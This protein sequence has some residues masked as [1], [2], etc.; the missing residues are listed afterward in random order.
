MTLPIETSRGAPFEAPMMGGEGNINLGQIF[1]ALWRRRTVFLSVAFSITVLGFIVLKLLTPLYDST[2]VLVLAAHQDGVVDMQQSYM[3]APPSDPVVRAEVDALKSRT[4]ID[5]VIDRA[6]LMMDPEF[7]QYARPLKP[8]PILCFPARLFPGFLQVKLGCRKPDSSQLAPEQVKYNVASQVLQSFSVTPDPKTYTVK[9]DVSSK[10]TQKAARLANLWADEYMGAQ[11][12]E[13]VAEVDRAMASLN[14]RIQNLSTNAERADNA[15]ETYKEKNHIV[16][17]SGAQSDTNTLALQEVQSLSLELASARTARAKL[18]SA[19][20]E[21]R[22]IQSDPSQA[23][24][25][26]AVAAAPLVETVREQEAN[27]AAQLASLQGTYG[28]RHP[29]VVSAKK[30]LEELRQRLDQ[31]VQRAIQELDVQVRQSQVNER[32]LQTRIDQLVSARNGENKTMPQL[33]QLDSA[34][35]AAK[36]VYD[37]FMQGVYRAAAQNG[38]PTPRGRV[39]QRADVTDWP[40][41]PNMPIFMA[42]IAVA[43]L[44]IAFGVVSILEASDDSFHSVGEL[45]G[46]T[47]LNVLGMTLAAPSRPA[48]IFKRQISPL[49]RLMIT[50]P[51]SALS[52]SLRLT[53]SAI[54]SS[55]A[56][57]L[58]KTVMITSAVPGEGKTTFAL[59]LGRQSAT[60]GVHSIVIEAE[61]RRP[62]F[63]R[64]L[65]P[66]P[67]KGLCDYLLGQAALE[68]V[69]GIDQASG[70]HFI[71]AGNLSRNCSELL[72]STRMAELLRSLGSR[73]SLIVIDTPPA[74]IV[75]DALQLSGM[76]DVA[77][78]LVKWASTP[79]HMVLDGIRKLQGAKAPL[80]GT[81]LA[82]VDARKY[83]LY[84]KGSLAYD[85]ARSYYTEA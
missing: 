26:P 81:V 31:E 39:V 44:M 70:L 49:S 75:A 48:F 64:D 30:Q 79:R 1:S 43:A 84:G 74:A 71:A 15:V 85:Y 29:L 13:K 45:E 78:L 19:Q 54:A 83:K 52:E 20:Q 3:N 24:T 46:A 2:V 37:A 63:G 61:M 33:R 50:E 73:Y 10:N 34:Q 66:L 27:A 17:L 76:I 82:Q 25:A 60:T 58:P 38:V 6:N 80:V 42:V 9:L 40:S 56:D 7:N 51:T 16:S 59:M 28:E 55:R 21:V 53:R 65:G 11:I 62:K 5:R 69:I 35:T 22:K 72:G 23:L 77:V 12:D 47:R 4:L 14:P 32:Q 67:A 18:E 57:R 36:S 8:N 68:E 41:F